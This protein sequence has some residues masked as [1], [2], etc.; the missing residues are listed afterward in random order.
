MIPMAQRTE[1]RAF[2]DIVRKRP[3]TREELRRNLHFVDSVSL[4]DRTAI[5]DEIAEESYA[6]V[7][8]YEQGQ[9]GDARLLAA[10]LAARYDPYFDDDLA[11]GQAERAAEQDAMNP[12]ELADAINRTGVN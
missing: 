7:A 9:H 11:G 8:L 5:L 6:I 3:L 10:E 12:R 1:L 4:G 2:L